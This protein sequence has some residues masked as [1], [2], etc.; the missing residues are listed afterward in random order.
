MASTQHSNS[1]SIPVQL[2]IHY[3]LI[4]NTNEP[5]SD[6]IYTALLQESRNEPTLSR[7]ETNYPNWHENPPI[8][9][10]D[11]HNLFDQLE[12]I[13]GFQHDNIRNM[14][15]HLLTMLNSRSARMSP[16]LA[17][18]SLHADYIGGEHANYR[19][20]YFAAH[21]NLNDRY[22][23][24][25]PTHHLLEEAKREWRER[26]ESLSDLERVGQISLYLL[27]WGE[28][29]TLR[30]TP[31][32]ICFLFYVADAYKPPP[33]PPPHHMDDERVSLSFLDDIISPIYNFIRD[34]SYQVIKEHYV[35]HEK[36]HDKIIGYDDIN[37][38][39]WNKQSI[40][41]LQLKNDE[42]QCLLKDISRE[43]QFLSLK[44]VDWNS[45]FRK[46][47]YEKRSWLHLL[48]NFSRVWIIHATSFWYYMAASVDFVHMDITGGKL[49]T[50]SVNLPMRLSIVGLGGLAAVSI[51]IFATFAEMMHLRINSHKAQ[52]LFVRM[53]M[54][55]VVALGQFGSSV[56]IF[57]TD[58]TS[59]LAH[60]LSIIQ[61][62]FGAIISILFLIIPPARL[63]YYSSTDAY[64]SSKAFTANFPKMRKDDRFLSIL[65]W[66]CVF[67]CKFLET[68][69]FLA[70]SF[71]DALSATMQ[72]QLSTCGKDPL[73]GRWLCTMIPILTTILMFSVE[74]ALFFLDTYLWYVIW[75][76]IFSVAQSMRLGISV[77]VSWRQLFAKVPQNMFAKIIA[78]IQ[79]MTNHVR[80]TACSQMWNAIIIS[81]Y[82]DHLLSVNNLQPLLYQVHD[83]EA[84]DGTVQRELLPPPIFDPT[85]TIPDKD[86]FPPYSEAERRLSFFAQ[87]LTTQFPLPCSVEKMPTFTVFTPHYSEKIL[88]SLREIIREENSTTRVTLLEYLKKLHP[89]E[90]SNFVKDTMFIAEEN[91]IPSGPSEKDDLPFYCIGFKSSAPEYTLRTR[92]W[93]SL[94]AQ[95]LYRTIN[96]FMNYARA[97]K[98]LH[99]IEYP[100]FH[101]LSSSTTLTSPT[102]N[103]KEDEHEPI[104]V[105]TDNKRTGTNEELLESVAH[106]KFRFLVAMQRYAK[107]NEEE[108]S[109]CEFLLTEYP[110]LQIAYID[111]EIDEGTQEIT[112]YSVLI[113]GQCELLANNRRSP[114]YRIRLPGNPIL[115]DGK[116]DNQ[117]HALIFYRGE[118]L[119]LVDANQD[120]Y[121]EECL[122]IRSIFGEFE[123]Q[124]TVTLERVYGEH[125][126][127]SS[128]AIVGAR[129][130]IFSEN[131]GMLG[132]VAAG[133]EQTFGTLTQRIMAKTGGRLHYGHPDFLNAVFMT[134]RGG[135]SKAQRGLHLN[136]DIYAGMNALM[137]GGIIKHTEYLQC[138][139]GRDLGFSSILN[140]TTKIGTGM[141][142]Q[143]LS[144]EYYYLGTQLPLDRFLTFYYA[145]P[146]FH[147]NNILILFA[148]QVFLFC[149]MM[150]STMAINLPPCYVEIVEGDCFNIKPVYDWFQRCILSIFMVFFISFLPLF[151]QELT[152]KGTGRAI[153]RLT[154][155]FLS[156]SPLFEIFMTQIYA[157]SVMSN[158][159][160]G[161]ARYIATGRGFATARIPFSVLYSRFAQPSIYFGARTMLML[162]FV[163]VAVWIPHLIYFWATV[164]SLLISP[165][166]FNP[167]QF[168]LTEFIYDYREFLSWLS[169]GNTTRY[170]DHAW[171]SYCRHVRTQVTGNKRKARQRS[172][173]KEKEPIVAVPRASLSNILISEILMPFIQC[174]LC[175]ACYAF[176]KS[177]FELNFESK[178]ERFTEDNS[179]PGGALGRIML[180]T[181]APVLYNALILAIIQM[182]SLMVGNRFKRTGFYMSTLAHTLAVLG[183]LFAY[184]V[185]WIMEKCHVRSTL[186][187]L[188]SVFSVQRFL[189][190]T[191]V[192][193]FLTRELHHDAT[194][195]AW[196]SGRW[197][198]SKVRRLAAREYIC[199]IV[200]MS[201][202]SIDF[203][204]GH[205]IL[206]VLFPITLIPSVDRI[207]SLILFWLRPSKQIRPSVLPTKERR[208]RRKIAL[209]YGP[210]FIFVLISF[211]ALIILPPQL[212]P[213][214]P[215]SYEELLKYF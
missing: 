182:I 3:N 14:H 11:I 197:K 205:F 75:N 134:T 6:S 122:K 208:R 145:H 176:Y 9:L 117:N 37:Q 160:F 174:C 71:R 47:F 60:I 41:S 66:V 209:I 178:D 150:V 159:S 35:R 100:N 213:R 109:N 128:V 171:I 80:Y 99:R 120:N 163:S 83:Q 118:Y 189:F 29:A 38:F 124:T 204:L 55:L 203:I 74:L 13:Y 82:R 58:S 78:P 28:A 64:L 195:R 132:D 200:E 54:L 1:V 103:K 5:T 139:K 77:M 10:N 140:F 106:Q 40:A 146:G 190:K 101:D 87:S 92:I 173:L 162:L 73:L 27:I 89:T 177:R 136:E 98:I 110:Y 70:L 166:I 188:L 206:F 95:T 157:N 91:D 113:D 93:A 67:S 16:K 137:R 126:H 7:Q 18:W 36:D 129:E 57:S 19:K 102:T 156:L 175:V 210:L 59:L 53:V 32:L 96:G 212:A 116:S 127:S 125:D 104:S 62:V 199:K 112:Y 108:I 81:M 43:L 153:W 184:E 143:F 192:G 215:T 31:E 15:D 84:E 123:H 56:Y 131:V 202:F 107:F 68:Y 158:L 161:G 23:S 180:V 17:L 90:W 119:Q 22:S 172:T 121:L 151:L 167:H 88:L 97:I 142:E 170:H 149:M 65:L 21:L 46:T 49:K 20:W 133:K 148:V 94:R 191:F 193:L 34:Q 4:Q 183:F 8:S 185:L 179:S 135:V 25:D 115:G 168:V 138:G 76:T 214:L 24:K 52:I 111:E 61:L 42:Q 79:S 144:R 39:F 105:I 187:A 181:L 130:Y 30:Y 33:P 51:M 165:F 196:W 45:A 63:F 86:Y 50:I 152:E 12:K 114:K 69:F 194:N 186:L 26:M 85:A 201:L 155:Q 141:G 147:L 154:K 44:D 2:P 72:M 198:A 48:T 164:T 169:R 211:S 207:H